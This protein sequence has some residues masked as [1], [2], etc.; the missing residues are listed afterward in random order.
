MALVEATLATQIQTMTPTAT[1]GVA[2]ARLAAAYGVYMKGALAGAVPIVAAAVDSTAVPAMAGAMA[3]TAGAT[4][5]AGAAVIQGGLVAFWAAMVAAPAVFFSGA[6]V[7]TPPTFAALSS[8]LLAT[9]AANLAPG[10]TLADASAALA[11]ALHAAT[12]GQGSATF[13][14]GVVSVI[15]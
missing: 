7:V 12:V 9:F 15:A 11:S 1:P 14:P 10:T 2:E 13:P 3:F 5:A 6:T 8:A 4:A